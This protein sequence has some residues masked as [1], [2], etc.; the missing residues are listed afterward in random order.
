MKIIKR[1]G[2]IVEYNR[3]KI[4]NAIMHANNDVSENNRVNKRQ[5]ENIIK[6]I[7]ELNKKRMLVED[8]Q[9][10]IETELMKIKKYDLAKA[11]IIY[12]YK[13]ALVRKSNI[14]DES[15]LSL[16]KS[17]NYENN[18]EDKKELVSI[19]RDLIA[20]EV[21]KD[22]TKRVL[23]PEKISEAHKNGILYF[24]DTE[25]FLQPLINSCTLNYKDIL[26]NEVIINENKLKKPTDFIEACNILSQII[27]NVSISQYGEQSINIKHLSKYLEQSKVKYKFDNKSLRNHLENGIK[28][29]MY[30]LNSLLLIRDK[31]PIT[32]LFLQLNDNKYTELIIDEI[33]NQ[34]ASIFKE[35]KLLP[36]II[37]LLDENNVKENSKYY[38]L[39][40]KVIDIIKNKLPITLM[41]SKI[42][43]QNYN[44]V[45]SPLGDYQLFPLFKDKNNELIFEGRFNQGIVSINL[46]Q[47]GLEANSNEDIFWNLLD[48]RLDLCFEALMCRYHSLL[49]TLS[50]TSPIHWQNGVISKLNR[51][52]KIDYFLK[53]NYSTLSLGYI[54]LNEL[55]QIIKKETIIEKNGEKFAIKLLKYIRSKCD[56]WKKETG[57]GF[58]L[59]GIPSKTLGTYFLNIDKEKFGIIRNITDKE[60]YNISHNIKENSNV[61]TLDKIKILSQ[62]QNICSGG[63]I[64]FI[65]TSEEINEEIIEFIYNN[66]QC[67][68]LN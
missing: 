56:S 66:I 30:Q 41:S 34:Y 38:Y 45:F 42:L 39:T 7:E 21:S 32:T 26:E 67:I 64:T 65:K 44:N 17:N 62:F 29:I 14:T 46:P 3:Q 9:D 28:I 57:I 6:H 1:D 48:E 10:M 35:S 33:L 51:N 49:G 27:F 5:I 11:Y 25:Y 43:K 18:H 60:Y 36:N 55:T 52:E 53:N 50:N 13:R 23:L 59:Y 63:D 24:H 16:I 40:E 58:V 31:S 20:S 61:N 47:I 54:G 37:Y 12:R 2:R 15:I 22:L 68:N 19:Q 8:I 4:E